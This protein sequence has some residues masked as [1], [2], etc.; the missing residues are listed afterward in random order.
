MNP[1][2]RNIQQS[3]R[4]W[5]VKYGTRRCGGKTGRITE[6]KRRPRRGER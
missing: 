2:P 6:R 4:E 3:K 1:N 5:R